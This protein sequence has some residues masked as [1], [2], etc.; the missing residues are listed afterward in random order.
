MVQTW[1]GH[2]HEYSKGV[3]KIVF[4][5]VTRLSRRINGKAITLSS[6]SLS[7]FQLF[8]TVN[9]RGFKCLCVF[10]LSQKHSC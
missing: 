6:H 8:F 7:T 9:F 10:F 5:F 2:R 3:E 1:T 4:L